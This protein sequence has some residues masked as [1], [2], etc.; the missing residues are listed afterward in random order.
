MKTQESICDIC[1]VSK[2]RIDHDE[3]HE[4]AEIISNYMEKAG[5]AYLATRK[6]KFKI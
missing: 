5:S 1:G 2:N 3:L 4:E 6:K